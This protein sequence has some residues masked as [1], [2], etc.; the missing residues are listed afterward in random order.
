[1]RAVPHDPD[2]KPRL[3]YQIPFKAASEWKDHYWRVEIESAPR[4]LDMTD[5]EGK[6]GGDNKASD[7]GGTKQPRKF[8]FILFK[9]LSLC[10]SETI[11]GR[12]TRIWKA[13][14]EDQMGRQEKD[15][16]VKSFH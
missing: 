12:A 10:R 8:A 9:F 15:R 16:E 6:G 1:M 3:S 2:Q 13:W 5:K 14:N 7:T 11:T 4:S